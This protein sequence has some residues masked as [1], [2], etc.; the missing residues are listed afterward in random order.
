ME[1]PPAEEPDPDSQT[2]S[3]PNSEPGLGDDLFKALLSDEWRNSA[4]EVLSQ[5]RETIDE[6]GTDWTL[7]E[8]ETLND[9]L[10]VQIDATMQGWMRGMLVTHMADLHQILLQALS[11]ELS[12]TIDNIIHQR[13]ET[14]DGE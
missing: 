6:H 10:K 7:A 11:E 9:A 2:E 1:S 5:A 14:P 8:T 12:T 4:S 3:A 13:N